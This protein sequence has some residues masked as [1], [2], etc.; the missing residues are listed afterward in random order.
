MRGFDQR[1]I[2]RLLLPVIAVAELLDRVPAREDVIGEMV[3]QVNE[4]GSNHRMGI[5]HG[6]I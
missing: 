2:D 3:M 6:G 4:P 1:L 5:D